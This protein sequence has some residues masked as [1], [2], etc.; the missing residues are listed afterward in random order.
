MMREMTS[1]VSTSPQRLVRKV[2]E[3]VRVAQRQ[4]VAQARPEIAMTGVPGEPDYRRGVT[5]AFKSVIPVHKNVGNSVV[6]GIAYRTNELAW[7]DYAPGFFDGLFAP[8]GEYSSKPFYY[9]DLAAAEIDPSLIKT[10]REDE[11][12]VYGETS[13]PT[14]SQARPISTKVI[15]DSDVW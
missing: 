12:P 10:A 6:G 13:T 9:T 3:T 4:Q 15:Q 14:R 11:L 7:R 1:G 8:A 2:N 5:E